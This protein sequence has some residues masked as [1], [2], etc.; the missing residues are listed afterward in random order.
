[1][2][3]F[4]MPAHGHDIADGH[5]TTCQVC[6]SENLGLIIELGHQPLC[7]SLLSTAQLSKPEMTYP[8]NFWRCK[9]CSLTQIDHAVKSDVVYHLEYPY[10]CGVTREV[11]MH[12]NELSQQAIKKLQLTQGS[13]VVDIGSNDGTLLKAFQNQGMKVCGVEP[14]NVASFAQADGVETYQA[15]FNEDTAQRVV[16]SHGKCDLLT[17]TNVFAHM[18]NLGEVLRGAKKLVKD[19]GTFIVEVHYLTNI[20]KNTQ[21]DSIYH[22]HLRT[23]SLKSLVVLFAMYDFTVVDAEVTERYSGTIRVYANN[24]KTAIVA[25]I[26]RE[27][28]DKETAFGIHESEV[29]QAF[30]QRVEKSKFQLLQLALEAKAKGLSFVGNSCPARSSTLLNYV[31]ISKD[32][33]PYI[34]EQPTSLK[35]NLHLP[36]KLIPIVNNQ[37]L[38]EEQPDYV[39]LLA[40]HLGGAIRKELRERGLRSKLVMPL[41]EVTI[42]DDYSDKKSS[43]M[44]VAAMDKVI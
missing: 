9:D 6:G 8:L 22:E 12:M 41:P 18:S 24:S 31:G 32:L 15:F 38:I 3:N 1:M 21:Y 37:R 20:L 23:Y 17:A 5:I 35:L 29:Y 4:K 34:C 30:A 7:D 16:E 26:I 42:I 43:S 40:W 27:L 44:N 2:S 39:V 10:K 33:M 14:T 28:L 25:P 11:V 13:F 36:G 19:S